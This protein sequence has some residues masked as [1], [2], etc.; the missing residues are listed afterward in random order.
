MRR[1][2]YQ[3]R[4]VRA[5]LPDRETRVLTFVA[6]PHHTATPGSSR[7]RR[8][9]Q[10]IATCRGDRGPNLEYLRRTVDHLAELGMRDQIA[11][12]CPRGRARYLRRDV[13]LTPARDAPVYGNAGIVGSKPPD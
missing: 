1:A 7:L 8:T 11:A 12:A 9:A 6:D 3:P 5:R 10:R 2:V 4:L 13:P